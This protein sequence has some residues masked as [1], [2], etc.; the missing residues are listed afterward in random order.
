MDTSGSAHAGSPPA[1]SPVIEHISCAGS[2][3]I[4]A[5]AR[6]AARPVM[7]DP[8][9]PY[10]LHPMHDLRD[11]RPDLQSAIEQ[12]HLAGFDG[13]AYV[14]AASLE[15]AYATALEMVSA[16]GGAV[17]RVEHALGADIPRE[18]QSAFQRAMAEVRKAVP[19]LN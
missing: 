13:E 7:A 4:V 11:F 17:L 19:A 14:L 10:D 3:P 12:L 15:G 16:I 1:R 5:P 8:I 9:G 2:Q 18:V 6:P